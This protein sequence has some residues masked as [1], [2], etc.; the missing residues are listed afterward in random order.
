MFNLVQFISIRQLKE[1]PLRSI[2]TTLGVS[3]GIA[4]YVA[5]A[6]INGSVKDSFRDHVEAVAGKAKLSVTAGITGFD[7]LKIDDIKKT[8]GVAY[9][10]PMVEAHAFFKSNEKSN[11]SQSLNIMGVDMLQESAVRS[12]KTTDQDIIDDPLVFLNQPDSIVVTKSFAQ[13]FNLKVD[14]K[15]T[16][17][18]GAG[19]KTFTVRGLLEPEGAAKAFGGSLAIMDIDGARAT[20]SKV[21]LVDRVDIVPE[22]GQ[23]VDELKVRLQ[24]VLGAGI[25]VDR[26]QGASENM[27][28]MILSYQRML[29]FFSTLALLVGLFL[30]YNSVSIS[31]FERRREIGT[32]RALGSE[33][34]SILALILSESLLIGFFGSVLGCVLGSLLAT[35]LIHQ[36]TD[37]MAAQY[38][39]RVEVAELRYP[40]SLFLNTL[41]IGMLTSAISALIPAYNASKIHP[42][43]T[44]KSRSSH[45]FNFE[46]TQIFVP[47][48]GLFCLVLAVIS[49]FM[50]WAR[51][52]APAEQITQTFSVLG[53]AL[54]GPVVV[55]VLIRALKLL[56]PQI[57]LP[58]LRLAFDNLLKS[59]KR[60]ASNIMALMVGLFLVMMIATTRSS[61]QKTLFDWLDE[62]LVSDI[63]VSGRGHVVM[64]QTQPIDE[65][66]G[67]AVYKVQGVKPLAEGSHGARVRMVQIESNRTRY[68]I[69]AF[70]RPSVQDDI[71]F[72]IAADK[73]DRKTLAKRLFDS[74]VPAVLVSENFFVKK[75]KC[76]NWR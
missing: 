3:F 48:L 22:D 58:M 47:L 56:L 60:T 49:T 4:L 25:D 59:Q 45:A 51:L 69:K 11:E 42:L 63:L 43:E 1:K 24:K 57:R 26:P 30:V 6:I 28:R 32:L 44:M 75:L 23:N 52:W 19:K 38:A 34:K 53:T 14:S 33:R 55:F 68:T 62:A 31:I 41:F 17:S 36:I 67:E 71:R 12:Y 2:L 72:F 15:F 27:E 8:Q 50:G 39:M 20:F 29:T 66:V 37:A 54:F 65:K 61:F 7:E 18:T 64:G 73:T 21:G 35:Q 46:K 9:A 76:Q 5:I 40:V 70:D 10:V 13:K 74:P 16:V